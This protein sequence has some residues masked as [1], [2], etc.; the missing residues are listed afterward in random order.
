MASAPNT[1]NYNVAVGYQAL[2]YTA[3]NHNVGI[4]DNTGLALNGTG[5]NNILI[6]ASANVAAGTT[7][8]A[9]CVGSNSI[10]SSNEVLLA[11]TTNNPTGFYLGTHR[12]PYSDSL[13]VKSGSSATDTAVVSYT[14]DTARL[15][16]IT[17][18]INVTALGAA[19]TIVMTVK[20]YL[21]GAYTTETINFNSSNATNLLNAIVATGN[22]NYYWP[23]YADAKRISVAITLSGTAT[24][25]P[26]ITIEK[27]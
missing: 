6:G 8:W 27:K 22:Y 26:N 10:V 20:Y 17:G 3:N 5:S 7:S 19:N 18:T 9:V 25:S 2:V 15:Y 21:A 16:A 12:V 1:A 11:S 13:V 24:Y 14:G 23:I 4:G